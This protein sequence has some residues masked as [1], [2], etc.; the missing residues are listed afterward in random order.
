M[1]STIIEVVRRTTYHGP[2]WQVQINRTLATRY[3]GQIILHASQGGVC[4][5]ELIE[6]ETLPADKV[7]D[8]ATGSRVLV[9]T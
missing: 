1:E 8:R 9:Q 7:L 6:H 5:V 2:N 3:T 4:A